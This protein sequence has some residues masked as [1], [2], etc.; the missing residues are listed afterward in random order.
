MAKPKAEELHT[1]TLEFTFQELDALMQGIH[2]LV[3][4]TGVNN[5]VNNSQLALKIENAAKEI[6]PEPP[7]EEQ[8]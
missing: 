5:I 6:Q 3:K 2:Y 1:Q 4:E 8:K 7:K